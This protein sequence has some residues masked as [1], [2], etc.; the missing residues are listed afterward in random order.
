MSR[1]IPSPPLRRAQYDAANERSIRIK[2]DR[3]ASKPVA[4]AG[5]L[6]WMQEGYALEAPNR[7]HDRDIADDGAPDHTGEAR[8]YLGMTQG[9]EDPKVDPRPTDWKRVA[10]RLDAD[11]FYVT[12]MRAAISMVGEPNRRRLLGGLACNLF[13][14][15]DVTR[16]MDIPDWCAGDVMYRALND[17]W[18]LYGD[19]PMGYAKKRSESQLDAEAAA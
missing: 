16:Q 15:L 12:P 4:L 14:P 5:L 1:R 8:S 13:T 9:H 7:L 6:R 19:R 10:R 11:G 2:G 17:L 3:I 18:M